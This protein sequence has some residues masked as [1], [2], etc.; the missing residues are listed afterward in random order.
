MPGTSEAH[1]HAVLIVEDG[2]DAREALALLLE[3]NGYRVAAVSGGREA[4]EMMRTLG[5]RPCVVLLD[6]IMPNMDGFTFRQ[7]Q[8]ASPELAA[9]PIV[10]LTGHEGMRRHALD[11]GFEAALLKPTAVEDVLATIETHC[12]VTRGGRAVAGLQPRRV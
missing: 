5:Y 8:L 12:P 3:L 2:S 1:A 4:L 9:I 11:Q 10:A 7:H 6:L